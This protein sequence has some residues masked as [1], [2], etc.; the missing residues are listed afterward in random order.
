LF[1]IG[2]FLKIFSE[3]AWRII[4]PNG[5]REELKK[6][7]NQKEESPVVAMFVYGSG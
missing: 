1:L 4:W 6:S 5:F 3:T 7:A 2:R